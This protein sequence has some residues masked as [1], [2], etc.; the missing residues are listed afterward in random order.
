MPLYQS[1][2]FVLRTYKLGESDQIVVFFTHDYGKIRAVARRS[3]SRSH[4][5][6]GYCQPL[7]LLNAILFGKPAQHLFRINSLDLVAS[8]QNLQEDF[9]L[10]RSG[11]YLTE[12][13]DVATHEFEPA[14]ELFALMHWG[15]QQ[16]SQ[17]ESPATLLRIFEL[18]LLMG[19]GYTPQLIFCASCMRDLPPADGQF[20]PPLGGLLCPTCIT[21]HQM[22]IPVCQ[23]T[24][25]LLRQWIDHDAENWLNRPLNARTGEELQNLLHAHLLARL[26]RELKSYAFLSL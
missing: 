4:R 26:G 19:M 3:H 22:T 15:L 21:P 7:R 8:F 17:V 20:S 12:L 23:D 24:L 18:R 16:L 25:A 10:L 14:P 9:A 1:Q 2:A 13:L 5:L 11:L 6:A